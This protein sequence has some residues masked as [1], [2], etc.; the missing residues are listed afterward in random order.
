MNGATQAARA[1]KMTRFER[2]IVF[3]VARGYFFF[4]AVCAV[5][6]FVA[7]VAV[8]T[9][10]FVKQELPP[11]V[12]PPEPAARPALTYKLLLDELQHDAD[13][14]AHAANT[15]G[16]DDQEGG[17][18]PAGAGTAGKDPLQERFD[19]AL[20]DLQ[21][22]FPEPAY[23]WTNQLE[24]VCTAGGAFGCFHWDTRVKR[25]GVVGILTTA[26]QPA[27]SRT[28][29][30][31]LLEVLVRVL[32]DA[33]EEKRGEL[34][35][36]IVQTELRQR[37]RFEALVAAYRAKVDEAKAEYARAVRESEE[38]HQTWRQ[39]GLYGVGSGFA[40]LIVVSLFL[41]FLSMERH[42]R[43]LELLVAGAA[44]GRAGPPGGG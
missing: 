2:A 17:A 24:R 20:R 42:T 13:R 12:P 5:L 34:I 21:A 38:Q 41:A 39:W 23:T 4:M 29:R 44:A 32:K 26:L 11:P 14:S 43:A 6:V 27:K 30:V 3:R 36:P 16:L 18:P 31:E 33:P 28:D 1:D 37:A 9:R 40:L 19:A 15:I 25:Q 35:G 7:G 10:G 8:G 22:L